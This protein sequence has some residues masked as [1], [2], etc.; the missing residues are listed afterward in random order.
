MEVHRCLTAGHFASDPA[1]LDSCL[2][3]LGNL[4]QDARC[5]AASRGIDTVLLSVYGL[6]P[7]NP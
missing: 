7:D 1:A 4:L 3:C 6:L 5:A 2:G